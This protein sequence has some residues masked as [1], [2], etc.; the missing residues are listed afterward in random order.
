MGYHQ[1]KSRLL[2]VRTL[3]AT[4]A[5][6]R[7]PALLSRVADQGESF[8]IARNGREVAELR[9]VTPRK[10][11]LAKIVLK[12]GSDFHNGLRALAA[13]AELDRSRSAPGALPDSVTSF[14]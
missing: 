8:A 14:G 5:T 7:F 12:A 10:E 4:E 1:V 2:P 3:T 13:E 6:E 9:P 11:P